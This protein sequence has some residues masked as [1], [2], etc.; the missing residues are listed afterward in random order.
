M[1]GIACTLCGNPSPEERA[2]I[3][4][5]MPDVEWGERI[6]VLNDLSPAASFI[7]HNYNVDVDA[8]EFQEDGLSLIQRVQRECGHLYRTAPAD[9]EGQDRLLG[10]GE[11]QCEIN[12]TV[13]SE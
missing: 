10:A 12:F 4:K 7:A 5:E 3:E 2:A 8:D 11:A 6:A 1:T 13:W 9:G